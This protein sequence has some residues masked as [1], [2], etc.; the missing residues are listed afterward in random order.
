M[1]KLIIQVQVPFGFVFEED[2]AQ[3]AVVVDLNVVRA[4]R[5]LDVDGGHFHF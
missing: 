2:D 4:D 1:H 5:A 3:G